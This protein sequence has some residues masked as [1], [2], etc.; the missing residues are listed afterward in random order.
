MKTKI[1]TFFLFFILTSFINAQDTNAN[2][3]FIEVT[4]SAETEIEP[5]EIRFQIGIEEYWKEEFEKGKV[6]KDYVTKISLK[7]IENNLMAALT[8]IGIN[9]NQIVIKEVGQYWNR[10]GKDFKKS[11]SVELV[12][13]D[14]NTIGKILENVN[15]KGVNS[16]KIAELKNKDITEYREQVKIEAMKAAKK[17]AAYL[18]ESVDEKLGKVLSVIELDNNSGYFWK[19]QDMLSN[20]I[21]PSRSS[22]DGNDNMKKIKMKYEVKIKFEIK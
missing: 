21:V 14:F 6:Y 18:L 2:S 19:P 11:K 3:R 13:T 1:S 22:D 20:S 12:L 5:D 9:E 10:S 7:E 17:K 4:G 16:M 8:E 15:I